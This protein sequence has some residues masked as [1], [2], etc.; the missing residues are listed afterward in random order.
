MSNWSIQNKDMPT[1]GMTTITHVSNHL[2]INFNKFALLNIDP[3]TSVI[4]LFIFLHD[5]IK[6][7]SCI[8]VIYVHI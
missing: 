1:F 3:T 4:K 8:I 5:V 6:L 7:S 2:L